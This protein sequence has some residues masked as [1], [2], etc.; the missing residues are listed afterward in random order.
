MQKEPHKTAQISLT[1]EEFPVSLSCVYVNEWKQMHCH[2]ADGQTLHP[3][4]SIAIPQENW[5]KY[6][7]LKTQIHKKKSH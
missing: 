4:G 7:S 6:A 2:E 1:N 5:M 3:K